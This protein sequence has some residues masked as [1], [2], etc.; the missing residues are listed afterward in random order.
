M[1][2]PGKFHSFY[3]LAIL[4]SLFVV[5]LMTYRHLPAQEKPLSGT[6]PQNAEVMLLLSNSLSPKEA[7]KQDRLSIEAGYA[8]LP[9]IFEPNRGQT[10]ARVR[11]VSRAG[12]RTLWL[13]ADEA[14]LAIGRPLRPMGHDLAKKGPSNVSL[15]LQQ[16]A[17]AVL[18]MKFVGANTSPAIE[19]EG[20][21]SGTVNY[22]L[23]KT[24]QWR[25]KIPTYARVRYRSLYP[26]IDLVFYGNNR[27]LEYDLL[28]APGADPGQ[29]RLAVAGA[30]EI[31]I[32][33]A[34]N[35]ILKT[36]QGE[37]VQRKPRI[38]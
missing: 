30:D 13:T 4:S 29:I 3:A 23:G 16:S 27:E 35:L 28:V 25:T 19:G 12:N 15:R 24:E 36:A 7:H 21:Q 20:R 17:P 2:C 9:L 18:R 10:D 34:G 26:G 33:D 8:N 1:L 11:F 32:D 22:F 5:C 6:R 38:S 14:V 37:V 31:R